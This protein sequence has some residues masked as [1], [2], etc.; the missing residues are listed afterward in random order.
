[1][2]Q[3]HR[4]V[5]TLTASLSG[6]TEDEVRG[7]ILGQGFSIKSSEVCYDKADERWTLRCELKWRA[8]SSEPRRIPVREWSERPG[9][10]KVEWT[11]LELPEASR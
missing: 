5:L 10:V 7:D 1:M 4:G 8:R 11:A 3:D 9:V 2:L 6:P